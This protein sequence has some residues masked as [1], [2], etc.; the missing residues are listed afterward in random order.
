M[1]YGRPMTHAEPPR[2]TAPWLVLALGSVLLTGFFLATILPQEFYPSDQWSSYPAE[3]TVGEAVPVM[4]MVREE[5][6]MGE[7]AVLVEPFGTFQGQW[8]I[9]EYIG[10]L[11][12]SFLA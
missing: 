11:L 2:N 7:E 3:R 9:W 6:S 10:D 12:W 4:Q 1:R 5:V 8:N